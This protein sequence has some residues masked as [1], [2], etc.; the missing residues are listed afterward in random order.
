MP[1]LKIHHI[2]YLVKKIEKAKQSFLS[3]GYEVEQDT[4]YDDIRKVDICFLIKDGY[5]VELVS[6]RS[7]DSVV[8]GLM[9]KYKNCPYHICYE[10]ADFNADF[11]ALSA[12]GFI[13]IDEPTPAP[14]LQGRDVV[15]L[16][17][18]SI[19]MIELIR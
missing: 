16:N 14:A 15:F 18:A 12:N 1:S 8:A 9:K 17:S 7:E 4:V 5:R 3:L 13:A 19:G 2:G 6:P 10:T 11:D